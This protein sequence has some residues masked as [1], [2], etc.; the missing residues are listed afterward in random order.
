V[1]D[2][3]L[4]QQQQQQSFVSN[5]AKKQNEMLL[6]AFQAFLIFKNVINMLNFFF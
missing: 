6:I 5:A 3:I 4:H 1:A 2:T